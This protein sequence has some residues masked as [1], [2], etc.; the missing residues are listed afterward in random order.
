M[1]RDVGRD[2]LRGAHALALTDDANL[3]L[4]V[5]GRAH[6][7]LKGDLASAHSP[8][9][10]RGILFAR[11]NTGNAA[12]RSP[13]SISL[14]DGFSFSRRP[15]EFLRG[16]EGFL[17]HYGRPTWCRRTTDRPAS[18]AVDVLH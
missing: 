7:A 16:N 1:S 9:M 8:P 17:G 18:C 5:V 15:Q 14:R 13:L 6:G 4:D 11:G 12:S 10:H 2:R 3:F